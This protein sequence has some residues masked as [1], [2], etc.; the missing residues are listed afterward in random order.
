[1]RILDLRRLEE[2]ACGCHTVLMEEFERLLGPKIRRRD[3]ESGS[4]AP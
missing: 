1:M 4:G 2:A 3:L